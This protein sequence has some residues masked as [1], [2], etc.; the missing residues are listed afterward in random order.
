MQRLLDDSNASLETKVQAVRLANW[1]CLQDNA[2]LAQLQNERQSGGYMRPLVALWGKASGG[3]KQVDDQLTLLKA[4]HA[5]LLRVPATDKAAF[6]AMLEDMFRT[7]F[8]GALVALLHAHPPTSAGGK[9]VHPLSLMA[10]EA[11]L[12]LAD[13][14]VANERMRDMGLIQVN[15][16][17]L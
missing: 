7:G 9:A 10:V 5:L 17:K 1:C 4:V 15:A 2:F 13:E 6:L 14:L 12:R 11:F 8:I 3:A 16:L